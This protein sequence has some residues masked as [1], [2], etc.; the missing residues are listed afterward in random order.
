MKESAYI[1]LFLKNNG[2]VIERIAHWKRY[3]W[4][5]LLNRKVRKLYPEYLKE[6]DP[7]KKNELCA[8]ALNSCDNMWIKKARIHLRLLAEDIRVFFKQF[9][10]R[11]TI[12][13]SDKRSRDYY[14]VATITKNSARYIREFILFY[15]ATGADRVYLYDNDSTDGLT[16]VIRPFVE[17][18]FVVY[19]RWPG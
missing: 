14:S 3:R 11:T 2:R 19:R 5:M 6:T 15:K 13:R 1:D 18:G 10:K 12:D 4:I 16:D 17:S 8:Q 7:V 9:G